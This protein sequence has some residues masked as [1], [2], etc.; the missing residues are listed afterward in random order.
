MSEVV[1]SGTVSILLPLIQSFPVDDNTFMI[2]EEVPDHWIEVNPYQPDS[3]LKF[4]RFDE[5]ESFETWGRGRIFN[6]AA[7]LRWEKNKS[8]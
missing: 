7:E 8:G 4:V 1:Y 2:L 5:Q 3:G 6:Q